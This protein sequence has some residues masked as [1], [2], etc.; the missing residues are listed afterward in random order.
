MKRF[1]VTL[2]AML[3]P[4]L[5]MAR[6][7]LDESLEQ[8]YKTNK[9]T[10]N[11]QKVDDY[12]WM[13][14]V[15]IDIAGR[16]PTYQEI[17]E[18]VKNP[19]PTK[20]TDTVNK[21]L[22]S[23]DYVNNYQNFWA[24][25]LRIRPER[26]SDD[27]AL[28]KSYPYME[29]VKT[30]IRDDISYKSFVFELLSAT[31]KYTSNPATG[32]MIRDN[33]MPLDNLATSLQLFIGKDIACAQCHDD[34]FQDYSQK[35]FYEMAAL[36]NPLDNRERRATYSDTLKRIDSEI[37]EITQKDRIDNNVRQLLSANLFNLSDNDEKVLKFPHDYKYEDAKPLSAVE[38]ASLDGKLKGLERGKRQA[39]SEWI[40]NHS[41]FQNAIVNRIWGNIV[42]KPLIA[43]ETNFNLE[44]S[45][46]GQVLKYIGEYFKTHDYSIRE[47][48]RLITT[49]DF[50]SRIAYTG[51]E[52]EYKLQAVLVKRMS[53]HQIWDSILTL[54]LPDVNYSRVSFSEY[55]VLLEIDWDS[56]SGQDALDAVANLREYD[57]KIT[58]NFL[59]YKN[60]DLVRSA[61][62][63]NTNSFMGQFLKEYGCSDR[64]L[65][66]SSDDNGSITQILTIMNSPIMELMLDKKSQIFQSFSKNSEK[67]STFISILGRPA[68]VQE[69]SLIVKVEL[70]D[71][72]WALINS[73]EFLFRI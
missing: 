11:S 56:L 10:G 5:S 44:D 37:K 68:N 55:S 59:K 73:R 43:P 4:V 21:I 41:D 63:M 15:S 51:K 49:S 9:V 35:Q 36:F 14:R 57:K 38:P 48:I 19:S 52:E 34:P 69:K 66:D 26:L 42:G 24:D 13:R 23:V 17:E 46:E 30:F 20:K 28:L 47:L 50:Y 12:Q 40:I 54:V 16:I 71:L 64:I 61:Y 29:Y 3:V 8:Y 25:L 45:A 53:A 1:I 7:E 39:A 65:L 60:I 2:V 58:G 33:G 31:G 70:A 62:C 6:N 27:V 67:D 32:Y 22:N 72:V 18:F